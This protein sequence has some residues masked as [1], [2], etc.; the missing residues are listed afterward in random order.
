[1]TEP[2]TYTVEEVREMLG[3]AFDRGEQWGVTYGGWFTPSEAD[4]EKNRTEAID[5]VLART[6]SDVASEARC[7][8]CGEDPRPGP[9][10]CDRSYG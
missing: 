2:R 4:T 1:M 5:K 3:Q 7:P 9:C 8:S 6:K 10:F